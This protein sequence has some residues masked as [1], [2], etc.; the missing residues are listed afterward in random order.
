MKQKMMGQEALLSRLEKDWGDKGTIS[1][2]DQKVIVYVDSA[3]KHPMP[4][5]YVIKT[6]PDGYRFASGN[7]GRIVRWT[8]KDY[9][10]D[11]GKT[12]EW[13]EGLDELAAQSIHNNR[14]GAQTLVQSE[15]DLALVKSVVNFGVD[16][17]ERIANRSPVAPKFNIYINPESITAG[18]FDRH[19]HEDKY[20][21]LAEVCRSLFF[22]S[23]YRP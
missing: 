19:T 15:I 22:E 23:A 6:T 12:A 8:P 3:R 7:Y 21:C 5:E 17:I 11:C 1:L 4:M 10:D 13:T 2:I 18:F 14:N 20:K 9:A 16:A